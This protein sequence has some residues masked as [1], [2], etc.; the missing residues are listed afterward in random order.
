MS[1]KKQSN[2]KQTPAK[3][4]ASKKGKM[5]Q[6]QRDSI[7][8]TQRKNAPERKKAKAAGIPWPEWKAGKR[9]VGNGSA[10]SAQ[11]DTSFIAA[12]PARTLLEIEKQRAA[13]SGGA[14]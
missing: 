5:P 13:E 8:A 1:T 6:A 10:Q 14:Q 11:S 4:G 3:K 9:P 7:A 2:K 12:L